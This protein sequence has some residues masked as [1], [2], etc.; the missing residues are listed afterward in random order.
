MLPTTNL[1]VKETIRL[2]APLDLKAGLPMTEAAN[3][4]VVNGRKAISQILKQQDPRLLVVVGP[5]S[6]HDPDGALEYA[7]RLNTLRQDLADRFYI[8]M[9]VYFEKP[10]TTVGWKGLIYDPRLD[11]T[12]N[13]QEGLRIG[14]QLLL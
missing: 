14:R 3:T 10:R 7:T 1:H 8:V 11:G 5:C 9:R 13:I 6:I 4:T 12:D 2:T